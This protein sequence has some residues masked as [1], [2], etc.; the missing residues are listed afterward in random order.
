M[1]VPQAVPAGSSPFYSGGGLEPNL[2]DPNCRDIDENSMLKTESYR[3]GSNTTSHQYKLSGVRFRLNS[4]YTDD[5]N[6]E[7]Y[8]RKNTG[9]SSSCGRCASLE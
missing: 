8:K 2:N 1:A 4:R 9:Q 6:N 5:F 7:T 3:K